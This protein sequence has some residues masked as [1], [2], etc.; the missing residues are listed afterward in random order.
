MPKYIEPLAFIVL[1]V[2]VSLILFYLVHKVFIKEKVEKKDYRKLLLCAIFGVY[3]NQSLFFIGIK[4]TTPIHG[5]LIMIAT[6][7]LVLILT[8]IIAKES[9]N[10]LKS[11]GIACG[12]VGALTLILGGKEICGGVNTLLGDSLVF[13]NACC[14]AIYLVMVKPLMQ[15]YHP[16]TVVLWTFTFG[17]IFALPTGTYQLTQIEWNSFTPMVWWAVASVV[18]GATFLVYLLNNIA[19]KN[20]SAAV[21]G[22]YIYV[23]PIVAASVSIYFGKEHFTFIKLISATMIFAGVYF[24]N[25]GSLQRNKV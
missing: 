11:I 1:R 3:L 14:F 2:G 18:I 16:I 5:A 15:K 7:I 13:I 24:V 6:P 20:A 10:L 12:A 25:H 19:L 22:I 23:Q 17:F 9:F 21:V 8:R 4:Y